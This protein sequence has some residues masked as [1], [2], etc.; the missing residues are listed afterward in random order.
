MDDASIRRSVSSIKDSFREVRASAQVSMNN[1][2]FDSKNIKSYKGHVQD[3]SKTYD[4]QKRNVSDLKGRYDE[5]EAAGKGNTQEAQRLRTEYYKQ[6][7][8]L[9]QLGD[10]LEGAKFKLH[11]LR[12]ENSVFTQMGN[13]ITGAG[14]GLK[15]FG[16]Q[17]QNVGNS[18]TRRITLPAIGAV[19]AV[20]GITAAFGWERLKGLDTAQAQLKGLG[21][22]TEDV[23][24]ISD[25]VTTAIEGGMTTMAEGTSVAAG[26]MAAGVEEGAELERYIKLVGDAAVGSGRPVGE[27]AQIFN[28]VQGSGKLMT[29]ELNM[30]EQGMPG[31]AQ[32][33]ADSLGVSQEEF[34]NMVTAGEVSSD[35]FMDVMDDF[36]GGMAS[37]Y[38][39]SWSGM[40]ANTKAYIGI[41]GQNLLSGVFEQSKESI[42]EFIEL[43]K[44]DAVQ[45]WAAEM[46]EKIGSAFSQ[47][48]EHIKNGIQ[49]FMNL[50][51]SQQKLIGVFAALAVGIGPVILVIGKVVSVFGTIM[52]VVGPVISAIGGLTSGIVTL[53][54]PMG[55]LAVA[56]PKVAAAISLLTGPVGWIVGALVG[57]GA[58]FT[59]AYLKSETFRNFI[60]M[61][62]DRFLEFIPTL[63]DFGRTIYDNFMSLVIPA[64]QAVGNFFQEMFA[65]IR[66]FWESDG[67]MVMEAIQNAI[68]AI[69][70][71]ISVAMPI[72]TTII[73]GAFKAVLFVIQL[74]WENIKGVINGGLN[75]I[76][77]IVQVFSGL[78]TGNFS[79]MWEGVKNIFSGAIEF[80]WNL[81]QLMFWGRLIKGITS[82]V[83]GGLALFR[84]FSGGIGNIFTNISNIAMTI[85]NGIRA[86]LTAIM[87]GISSAILG[88]ARLLLNGIRAVF[89]GIFN[90]TKSIF[91]AVR[92]F[93]TTIWNAI[94]NVVVSTAQGLASRVQ[95]TWNTLS[96]FTRSIFNA[97]KNFL[98]AVWNAIRNTVVNTVKALWNAVKAVFNTFKAVTSTIFNAIKSFLTRVWTAIRNTVINTVRALWNRVRNIWNT[99]RG[100]TNSTFSTIRNFLS[101]TWSTIRNT[102]SNTVQSLWSRVRNIWNTFRNITSNIFNGIKKTITKVWTT[103][104]NSVTKTVSN[105]WGR[106]KKTFNTM[107]STLETIVGEIT[108]VFDTMTDGVKKGINKLIEGVNWVADKIGM[109]KLDKIKLSTGTT[110]NETVNRKIKTTSDGAL[111]SD[112]LATV[113]DR[114]PGNG[115]GGFRR[116][117]I[118]FPNGKMSMTPDKDTNTYLPKGSRVFNGKQTQQIIGQAKLSTGTMFGQGGAKDKFTGMFKGFGESVK[119]GTKKAYN[120]TKD[121]SKAAWDKAT[122]VIGDVWDYATNPGKLVDKALDHFGFSLDIGGGS[123]IKDLMGAAT[124]KLKDSVKN[125]FTGWLDDSDGNGDGSSFTKFRKTTPYSPNKP[126][127]GYPTSFNGGKHFGIDYATPVGTV[128]KAPTGG[129]VSKLSDHGGGIVAKLLQGKFTQFFMHL[130][131]VLKTGKVKQGDAI[132]KTGNSGAWTTAP[133][134]HYQVEKGNSPYVTNKNTKDPEK[135]LGGS[136]GKNSGSR[137]ASAWRPQVVQALKM[138][139]LPTSKKYV[140]A[141]IKQI[142][143][144]SGG[145]AGITQQIKDVNSG[146]NEARGLVQVIPPTFSAYKLPGHGNIMNG[147]DNLAAGMNYAKSRYGV[148]GMLSRIGKGMGYRTGGFLEKEGLFW[149]AEGDKEEAL[150][151]MDRPSEAMKILAI[152]GKKLAGKGT[153]TSQ[154]PNVPMGNNDSKH[155]EVIDKMQQQIDLL[156]QLVMSNK[157]IAD[158]DLTVG[159]EDIGQANNRFDKRN[160]SKRARTTGRLNYGV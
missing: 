25:Q 39:D 112:T 96:G 79:G 140:D 130:S 3:L 157:V 18:L 121:T 33:M 76:I 138:N 48:I 69:Q 109:D 103:I 10:Q 5:L 113:G 97:V 1:I 82:L 51:T 156:T 77:G 7:G 62:K 152:V 117:L 85:W 52:T 49:W 139:K 54:S 19:T 105:L 154:L 8:V 119:S 26:A 57:L 101:N 35:Q 23:G 137:K 110:H 133:H 59:A 90:V 81:F 135:F 151:P 147:L 158:K 132:A 127:P 74:V 84:N 40:V 108:G 83:Q 46:G 42:A 111:K 13:A 142:D 17:L 9:N 153:H 116:E 72:I 4:Q 65:K 27:M 146:G 104:Y 36:A 91:T 71:V 14:E 16:G 94:R 6:V 29:Q 34:R 98:S 47:V 24:R 122:D 61:L 125:L 93:I 2:R 75:I 143:T 20:G 148:A 15:S 32:A 28:R 102:V 106:V 95:T 99:F 126:V 149:G 56:F 67:A 144:E 43:L 134:L 86:G 155:D 73:S 159:D 64:V 58:A 55:G 145:N 129:S 37:A 80:V 31:F 89:T 131:K 22:N 128:I 53:L 21:Y 78:L 63:V 124:K 107:K 30:I 11:D 100:T 60:T 41:I 123:L 70:T 38:A 66:T 136:G 44:S 141:W 50:E 120:W 115:S 45:E 68:T 12:R 114:G 118:Q 150:I 92:S 160:S 88:I 87:N